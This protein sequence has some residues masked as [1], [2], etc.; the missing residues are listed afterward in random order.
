[1]KSYK[2]IEKKYTPKEIAE[3]FVFPGTTKEK[4]KQ[5][6]IEAFQQ[7]RKKFESKQTEKIN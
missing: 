5:E 6:K 7:Y 4:E 1:M 2:E 3:S